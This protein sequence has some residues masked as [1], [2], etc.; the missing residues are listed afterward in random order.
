MGVSKYHM[1][2]SIPQILSVKPT[3][4]TPMLPS[5]NRTI[6][7]PMIPSVPSPS[8]NST[9]MIPS[10]KPTVPAPIPMVPSV[11][12]PMIPT[13]KPTVSAPI[14]M[15]SSITSP[16]TIP[17]PMVSSVKPTVSA[18]IHMVSSITSPSTVPTPMIPLVINPTPPIVNTS[19]NLN[20]IPQPVNKNIQHPLTLEEKHQRRLQQKREGQSRY[21][22]K[23]KAYTK[24]HGVKNNQGKIIA[25]LRILYPH[26]EDIPDYILEPE[27]LQ[28]ISSINRPR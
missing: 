11:P 21:R 6:P 19:L 17:T 18:P 9:P 2:Q 10:V 16:S 8:T 7:T 26:L 28:F 23:S 13:I 4:P 27:V 25:L 5:I 15:V 20:V 12:T 24:L 22:E 14:P 1:N 3:V